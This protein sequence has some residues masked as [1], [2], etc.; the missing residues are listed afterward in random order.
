MTHPDARTLPPAAQAEKR[1]LAMA[2]REAGTSFSEVGRALGVHYMTVSKWWDRYQAGVTKISP[3]STSYRW[4]SSGSAR[5]MSAV[6]SRVCAGMA[7][8]YT[9][10]AGGGKV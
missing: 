8:A 7:I 1:R 3:S 9:R 2:M 6:Y 5:A 10:R 4:P